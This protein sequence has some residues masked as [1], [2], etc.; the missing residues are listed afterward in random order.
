MA[1]IID[2]HLLLIAVVC[3]LI[4]IMAMIIDLISGLY[5]AHLRG[6]VRRSEMLKRTGYKFLVYVGSMLIA[7][8][9]DVMIHMCK[10][11]TLIHVDLLTDVPPVTMIMGVF[12]CFVEFLSVREKADEKVHSNI[13]KAEKIIEKYA[14]KEELVSILAE[15]LKQGMQQPHKMAS[16]IDPIEDSVL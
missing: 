4:V 16:E 10:V 2:K 3:I 9:V 12:W 13:S 7:T 1:T 11:F 6:D 14:T 5:K 15:A 8:G